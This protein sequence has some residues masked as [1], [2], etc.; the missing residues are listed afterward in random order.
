MRRSLP[1]LICLFAFWL[2]FPTQEQA[3]N[4]IPQLQG[5][6]DAQHIAGTPRMII[7]TVKTWDNR[8]AI[9]YLDGYAGPGEIVESI[10]APNEGYIE[11]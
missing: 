10:E 11:P 8:W 5:I 4:A 7:C 2:V 1:I 6:A 9:P 3:K